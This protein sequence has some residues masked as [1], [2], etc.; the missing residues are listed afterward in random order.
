MRS[1]HSRV[2]LLATL[3]TGLIT[4][5]FYGFS[6]VINP[7]LARLPDTEYIE[8]MQAINEAIQNPWFGLPFF[9]APLLLSWAAWRQRYAAGPVARR[10]QLAALLYLV[11]NIGVTLGA[12]VP[13]NNALAAFPVAHAS[14]GQAAMVRAHFARAWTSWHT[15]R[16]GA[17]LGAWGLLLAACLADS[18]THRGQT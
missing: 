16:T 12:N 10:L 1:G 4:G 5:L 3:P 13:L 15:V 17:C 11:G 2:L 9:G 6:V 8:T 18:A 14:A 7:A